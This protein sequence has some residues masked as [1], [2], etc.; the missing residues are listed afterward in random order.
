MKRVLVAV[1]V[2]FVVWSVMD[3]VIHGVILRAS[4]AA[5]P[6]LWRPMSEMKT[7]VLYLSV[8]IAALTFAVIYSRLVSRKGIL[9]GLQ[10]GFLFGLGTGVSMG[11]GSYSVM[12]IPYHMAL[13]WF[14][15][16]L[17]E[18]TI[19]GVILGAVIRERRAG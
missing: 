6:S 8:F 2:I 16:T 11:Y 18:A 3:F 12:P 7:S 15:G 5:T 13:I 9:S 14:L 4:Y 19:G 10:Y 17:V 1:I